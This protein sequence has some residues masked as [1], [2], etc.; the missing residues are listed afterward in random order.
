MNSAEISQV[1]GGIIHNILRNSTAKGKS[2]YDE[3]G[4]AAIDPAKFLLS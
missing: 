3:G 2:I 1:R 4:E